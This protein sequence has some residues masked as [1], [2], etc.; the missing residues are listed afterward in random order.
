MTVPKSSSGLIRFFFLFDQLPKTP[1]CFNSHSG[2]SSKLSPWGNCNHQLIA[3]SAW[4]MN[5]RFNNESVINYYLWVSWPST[6]LQPH[7]SRFTGTTSESPISRHLNSITQMFPYCHFILPVRFGTFEM[8]SNPMRDHTGRLDN[9]RSLL[10]GLGAGIAEAIVVVCPME[11]LK[12]NLRSS[13]KKKK[14]TCPVFTEWATDWWNL[15]SSSR[16]RWSTT[17]VPS[18]RATE[19]SFTASVR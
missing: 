3:S 9:T 12:V 13:S 7:W 8:L 4:K 11:T 14:K 15:P 16:W 10:C 6:I 17:S 18:D 5:Q 1:R 19:A 2:K